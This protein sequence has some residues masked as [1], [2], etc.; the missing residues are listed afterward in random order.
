[1]HGLPYRNIGAFRQTPSASGVACGSVNNGMRPAIVSMNHLVQLLLPLFDG[2]GAAVPKGSFDQ[3]RETLVARFGGLTA[4]SQSPARGLW[5]DEDRSTDEPVKDVL[6][7]YEVMV[8]ELDAT[9]WAA[10]RQELA[11][12][13]GQKELVVRALGIQTL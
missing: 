12:A 6:V 11:E 9:W 10:Y 1:M 5:K 2:T 7:V 3:V 4:Y 8:E 13:F